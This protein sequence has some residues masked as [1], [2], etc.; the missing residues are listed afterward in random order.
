MTFKL[1]SQCHE[2]GLH[3]VVVIGVLGRGFE[4]R[5][6]VSVSKLLGQVRGHL[7]SASEVTFIANQNPWDVIGKKVL[8]ALLYPGGQ[9]V[10]AGNVCHVVHK[11]HGVHVPVVVLH[12]ALPEA[13]LACSVPQLDL[14]MGRGAQEKWF[15]TQVTLITAVRRSDHRNL[16]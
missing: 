10:E 5:H 12:H 11:H 16:N 1:V 7:N 15:I 2:N 13:L 14:K 8:L 4:Q 9:A 3:M 6:A